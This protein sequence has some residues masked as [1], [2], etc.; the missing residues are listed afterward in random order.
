MN[1]SVHLHS[2]HPAV[3]SLVEAMFELRHREVL[4]QTKAQ[5]EA[6]HNEK[7]KELMSLISF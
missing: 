5:A 7:T 6:T 3:T 2:Q 4:S 1:Q